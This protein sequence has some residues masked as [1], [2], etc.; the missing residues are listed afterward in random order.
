MLIAFA[1]ITVLMLLFMIT[2]LKINPFVSIIIASTSL[3][4][5]TGM[6]LNKVIDS[7][8]SGMGTTLGFIAIVLGIGAMLGKMLEESGGAERIAK[9]L[10]GAFGDSNIHWAMMF[11]G[12]VVGLPVF[13]QVGFVLLIPIVFT[14]VKESKQS[15]L[16][17]GLPL[18]SGLSVVH[19]LVPPHPAVMTAVDICKA[20]VGKTILY[21]IV[22]GLP[23]AIIAGPVF[24]SFVSGK[25]PH[26][27]VPKQFAHQVNTNRAEHEMPGFG[28]SFITILLPVLLMLLGTSADL[29]LAPATPWFVFYKFVGSPFMALLLALLFSFFSFGLNRNLKLRQIGRLCD[30]SLAPMTG[31]LLI[32]GGG[33]AFNKVMQDSGVNA[34]IVR[35]ASALQL[36]PIVL[37]WTIAAII[38]VATGSPTVSMMAAAG[39]VAPMIANHPTVAPEIIVLALGSGAL[40]LSHVNCSGF[41]IVKEY[42]GMTV[43]ETLKTWTVMVTILGTCGLLFT[44]LLANLVK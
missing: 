9:T 23:S 5:M 21:A 19:G 24:G 4:L 26:F 43:A 27:G 20:N 40:V 6:P 39:I 8:Q 22:V 15:L 38:R 35:M 30:R 25:M 16:K 10:I 34:E 28:I 31:I 1:G 11:V 13:F 18:V 12:V 44:M 41:W 42:F 3:G 17:V 29:L 37:T 32:I 36:S 7:I 2:F 14:I 33:G